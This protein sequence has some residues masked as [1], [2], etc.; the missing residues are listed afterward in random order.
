MLR[1]EF[2]KTSQRM[3]AVSILL[4]GLS[5]WTIFA[6]LSQA[7]VS[8]IPEGSYKNFQYGF[9]LNWARGSWAE[10]ENISPAVSGAIFAMDIKSADTKTSDMQKSTDRVEIDIFER[11]KNQT[12]EEWLSKN[13]SFDKT[14]QKN[15]TILEGEKLITGT[16]LGLVSYKAAAIEGAD[17]IYY[18]TMATSSSYGDVFDDIVSN[19]DVT[20]LASFS[21]VTSSHK[22]QAAIEYLVKKGVLQGYS[23]GTFKPDQ[24][25]NR[26]EL[27]KIFIEGQN[28]TPNE[29]TYK[30]CFP[31][32]KSDW[33]AKYVCYAKEKGWVQGYSDGTFKPEQT[34][35]KVEAIKMLIESY[36][37]TKISGT[38]STELYADTD[39]NEWYGKY[40][41]IAKEK[42]LLEETGIDFH[43]ADG[44]KRASIAENLY[45]LL[46]IQEKKLDTYPGI[47]YKIARKI[48][49]I[50]L[51]DAGKSGKEIGCGDSVV[52]V[53][54]EVNPR[55]ENAW[56]T[57]LPELFAQKDKNYGESGLYNALYQSNLKVEKA[58]EGMENI[59]IYITGDLSIGGVC[60]EARIK[61][62]IMET[63]LQEFT[64]KKIGITI[65]GVDID[66]ALSGRGDEEWKTYTNQSQSY[67]LEYPASYIVTDRSIKTDGSTLEF[68]KNEKTYFIARVQESWKKEGESFA[69][70]DHNPTDTKSFGGEIG[71]IYVLEQG[72]CDGPGCS[73]PLVVV[74]VEKNGKIY[75]LE[76][77]TTESNFDLPIIFNEEE[78]NIIKSFKFL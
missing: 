58:D 23:D 50:A 77:Y 54:R 73:P 55:K 36:K 64:N 41:L 30:N 13:T 48:A 57:A 43:P 24:T 19:F 34:V 14:T 31:D 56:V 10:E 1:K 12:L 3:I 72:S 70:L 42:A 20:P 71:Y 28:I 67:S 46:Q 4:A 38:A 45:R 32:V 69:Y 53:T 76:F 49:M 75:A 29:T 8:S 21:D 18:I 9:T 63:A 52:M 61:A 22:N 60:D 7:E 6:P 26:A 15:S 62:Q 47:T 27:L 39:I 17:F 59:H 74:A 51:D 2:Q 37:L 11:Q 40:I 35:N 68:K 33:Y 65:N 66:T 16:S 5:I 44:M 78:K 25:V